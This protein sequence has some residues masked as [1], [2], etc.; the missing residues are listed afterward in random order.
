MI[1]D[2]SAPP[3]PEADARHPILRSANDGGTAAAP[4]DA[5][6]LIIARAIGRQIARE[7]L[8]RLH[9]PNDNRSED[10]R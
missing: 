4:I 5:R 6:L 2:E 10:E 7:Q 1:P 3:D 9:A 8:D